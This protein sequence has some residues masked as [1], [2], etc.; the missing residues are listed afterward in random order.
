MANIIY[1]MKTGHLVFPVKL[2]LNMRHETVSFFL[3]KETVMAGF[4]KPAFE[5]RFIKLRV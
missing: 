4:R 1:A 3:S 2:C 5:R